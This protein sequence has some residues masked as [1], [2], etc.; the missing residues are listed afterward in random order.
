MKKVAS[1]F[2]P[3][4]AVDRRAAQPLHKQIYSALRGAIQKRNLSAGEKIPSS[5]ELAIDLRVSRIPVLNAYAQL[6][7]EGFIESRKGVG[8]F[9]CTEL[10]GEQLSRPPSTGREIR[11]PHGPR[12]LSSNPIPP[13][14]VARP[15]IFGQGAFA[16]GQVALEHFPFPTWS[17]LMARHFRQLQ[18]KF[19][20]FSD[21]MG[22]LEFRRA[23]ANYLRTSRAVNCEAEQIMIVSGSQQALEVTGRV[24]FDSRS[25]VWIEDPSYRLARNALTGTGCEIVPVPVDAEGLDVAAG[26]KA[27]RRA[28]GAIVTPSHQFPLGAVMTAARRLQLLEWAEHAG[29]WIIEDDYDSEYRYGAMPISS[30]QGL[31]RGRRVIYIGTFSKTLFPAIRVGYIVIPPDLVDRFLAVR[32]SADL[33][34]PMLYQDVLRRFIEDGHYARHIRRTR[35]VYQERRNVLVQALKTEFD[36]SLPVIGSDAGLHLVVTIPRQLSDQEIALRAVESKLWL[37]PLSAHY[38]GKRRAQGFVLGYGSAGLPEIR[39]G[40]R[41]LHQLLRKTR[42]SH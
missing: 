23:L 21:P 30:L 27:A 5:R 28:R 1:G 17:R 15:W 19:L 3:V 36:D 26:I 14:F 32:H 4:I 29:A 24:L 39:A 34:P 10:P 11:V 37:Y 7:A 38:L 41:R 33:F 16:I 9:V 42:R 25:Q 13:P 12:P 40:V 20:N 8:T 35:Q 22:S 6:L 2:L 18:A 31:D